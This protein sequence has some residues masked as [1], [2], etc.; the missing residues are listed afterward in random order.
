VIFSIGSGDRIS[1]VDG[2]GTGALM[3]LLTI[4]VLEKHPIGG[5]LTLTGTIDRNGHI[6]AI[7]GVIAKV[8]AAKENEKNP[9]PDP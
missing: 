5:S 2:P 7:G 9:V 1:E 3:T 4:S 6:G 8:T